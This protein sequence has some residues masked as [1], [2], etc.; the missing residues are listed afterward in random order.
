MGV[1]SYSG[2]FIVVVLSFLITGCGR[3]PEQEMADVK[4]ALHSAIVAGAEE[5]ASAKLKSSQDLLI[6]AQD[7]IEQKDYKVAKKLAIRAKQKANEATVLAIK[8]K[9]ESKRKIGGKNDEEE[10]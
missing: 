10:K 2:F 6:E 1:K 3:I 5:Y 9:M 4:R 8:I 7:K